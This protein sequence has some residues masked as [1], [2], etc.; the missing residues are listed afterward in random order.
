MGA[1][2][3]GHASLVSRARRECDYIGVSIFVNPAQFGEGE[4]YGKYP[5]TIQR[6]LELLENIGVDLV[7]TP[8]A[9]TMY[10]EGFQTWVTVEDISAPLEGSCR[11]GHFRGV[12]TVVAK[13][14]NA[15]LP[16]KAYFGQKDAQQVAVLKRMT[17][18]LNFP[19][20][21]VVCPTVREPDG[22][23]MSSRNSY[24]SPAE[25]QAAVVLY[26]SLTAAQNAYDDGER[27]A[28]I[29]R[30]MM[31]QIVQSEPMATEQYISAAD[32][33]TLRELQSIEK[34]VLFSM[35]VR[36]GNVRLI[37]N[38]LIPPNEK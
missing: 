22:L 14:L 35:A 25:R 10:P 32:P 17:K 20:E 8:P 37:D 6:D 1:L 18:D 38:I 28:D 11:P 27:N 3:A 13:L 7:W 21:L 24:L 12:T 15:F 5:R 26:R 31:R 33:E 16:D 29:L 30:N 2:H 34:G 4:D 23:A 36:I 9:D 19:V